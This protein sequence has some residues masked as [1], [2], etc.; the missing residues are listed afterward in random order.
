MAE[1]HRLTE[2]NTGRA[3]TNAEMQPFVSNVE[4]RVNSSLEQAERKIA[5]YQEDLIGEHLE[6]LAES[7]SREYQQRIEKFKPQKPASLG[8][9]AFYGLAGNVLTAIVLFCLFA[10]VVLCLKGSPVLV[11]FFIETLQRFAVQ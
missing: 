2:L 4:I 3:P 8:T 5:T 7:Y 11:Q 10:F 6:T 9:Q 1:I